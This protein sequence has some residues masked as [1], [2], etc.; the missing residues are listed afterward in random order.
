MWIQKTTIIIKEHWHGLLNVKKSVVPFLP[1][2]LWGLG[3]RECCK[4]ASSIPNTSC[5]TY[6][7]QNTERKYLFTLMTV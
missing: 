2:V 7:T 4:P 5:W 1:G 3:T 6:M